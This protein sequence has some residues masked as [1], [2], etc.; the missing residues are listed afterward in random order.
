M[1]SYRV[2]L[3]AT[4]DC[5]F[6]S[7]FFSGCRVIGVSAVA[8][9]TQYRFLYSILTFYSVDI[10]LKYLVLEEMFLCVERAS[11]NIAHITSLAA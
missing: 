6:I 1:V 2:L 11:D 4:S 9:F 3:R 5:V 8:F 7:L 10:E